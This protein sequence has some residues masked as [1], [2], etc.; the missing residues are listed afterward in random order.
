MADR[1]HG[2]PRC[3]RAGTTDGQL[4]DQH[5]AALVVAEGPGPEGDIGVLLGVREL[6]RADVPVAG[7]AAG[8]KD[9]ALTVAVTVA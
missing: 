4:A 6:R 1:P 3:C 7:A 5:S 8:V 2:K 9:A